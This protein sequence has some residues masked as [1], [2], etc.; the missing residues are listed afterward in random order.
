MFL[1]IHN[2]ILCSKNISTFILCILLMQFQGC[3]FKLLL[4]VSISGLPPVLSGVHTA[5]GNDRCVYRSFK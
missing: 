5:S 1:K 3:K 2:F 4:E